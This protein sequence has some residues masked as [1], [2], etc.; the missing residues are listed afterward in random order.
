M[1]DEGALEDEPLDEPGV[2]P[3]FEPPIELGVMDSSSELSSSRSIR[4]VTLSGAC[5]AL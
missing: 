5:A 4:V 1:V 3:L 2:E